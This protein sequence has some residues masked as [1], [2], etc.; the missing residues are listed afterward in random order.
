MVLPSRVEVWRDGSCGRYEARLKRMSRPATSSK[1][2][3]SSES[4]RASK[5]GDLEPG[6]GEASLRYFG[7]EAVT[8][9]GIFYPL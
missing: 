1:K 8:G 3:I 2:P 4:R 6:A 9:A 5:T 7:G